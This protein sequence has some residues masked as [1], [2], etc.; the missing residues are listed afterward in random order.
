MEC[1]FAVM[2][3]FLILSLASLDDIQVNHS[4][5][6]PNNLLEASGQ[7]LLI[8]STAGGDHYLC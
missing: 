8:D 5:V 6:A 4:D 1:K 3:Y 7:A 2:T